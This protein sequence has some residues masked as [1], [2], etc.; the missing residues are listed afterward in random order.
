[1]RFLLNYISGYQQVD[2]SQQQTVTLIHDPFS[3][4]FME[5][6]SRIPADKME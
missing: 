5:T 3:D 1:M 2:V 4:C 6:Y